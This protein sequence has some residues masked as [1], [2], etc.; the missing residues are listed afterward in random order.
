MFLNLNRRTVYE[1]LQYL[2]LFA[3]RC[4]IF[5]FY[6]FGSLID[7]IPCTFRV[8]TAVTIVEIRT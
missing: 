8:T 1:I 5:F 4:T 3:E 7:L 2:M 6:I